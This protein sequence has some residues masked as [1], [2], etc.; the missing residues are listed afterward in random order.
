MNYNTW[1]IYAKKKVGHFTFAIEA[2][3]T[4]GYIGPSTD[5]S[6]ALSYSTFAVA[7]ETNWHIN[8][9]WDLNFKIGHAP[10]QPNYNGS[11]DSYKAFYFNSSKILRVSMVQ[12]L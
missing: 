10:G 12:I 11:M 9:T 4:S 8:D 6:T 1:D 3:L 7:T 5:G 2:P